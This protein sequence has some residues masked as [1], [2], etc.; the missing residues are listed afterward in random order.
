MEW[1][2]P[3]KKTCGK[4]TTEVGRHQ[5]GIVAAEHKRMEEMGRGYRYLEANCS[6]GQGPMWAVAPLK[7]KNVIDSDH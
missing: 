3:W 2:I 4:T 1:K 5:E 7:K 6:R